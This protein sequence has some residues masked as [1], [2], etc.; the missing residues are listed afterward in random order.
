MSRFVKI[1]AIVFGLLV[2]LFV[3]WVAFLCFA[4]IYEDHRIQ[5][6]GRNYM[7]S[8]TDKD[9]QIWIQRT[10]KYLNEDNPKSVIIAARTVPPELKQLKILRIDENPN[11]IDYLWAGLDTDTELKVE[12]MGGGNFKVIAQYND[13]TNRVIWRRQ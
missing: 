13:E 8:L 3:G 11:E 9:I 6:I 7:D 12:R 10:Q 1:T 4:F 2:F 5:A